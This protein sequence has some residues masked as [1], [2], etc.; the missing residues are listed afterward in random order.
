MKT[1]LLNRDLF[2][3]DSI[4]TYTIDEDAIMEHSIDLVSIHDRLMKELSANERQH[5]RAGAQTGKPVIRGVR[6]Y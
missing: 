1:Y 2:T 3:E 5:A 6:T 4:H